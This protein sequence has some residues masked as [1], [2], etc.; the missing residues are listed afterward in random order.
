MEVSVFNSRELSKNKQTNCIT[1]C[2][3]IADAWSYLSQL[4]D[5]ACFYLFAVSY[6]KIT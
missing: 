2:S 5:E 4:G 3:T 1:A 6:Q